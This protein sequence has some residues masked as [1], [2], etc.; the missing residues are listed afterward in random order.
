[1]FI[2]LGVWKRVLEVGEVKK[3]GMKG[4]V[5]CGNWVR[6][7]KYRWIGDSILCLS[8]PDLFQVV[9]PFVRLF[10]CYKHSEAGIL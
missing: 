2:G 3:C 9:M 8:F 7:W 10:E 1:M 6:F 4:V 5:G